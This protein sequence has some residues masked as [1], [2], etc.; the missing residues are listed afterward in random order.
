MAYPSAVSRPTVWRPMPRE[1]PVTIATRGE[2]E[3][4]AGAAIRSRDDYA[5]YTGIARSW[6]WPR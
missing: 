3:G 2:A 4:W 1:P 6:R 5:Y